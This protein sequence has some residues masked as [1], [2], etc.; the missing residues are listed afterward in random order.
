[1]QGRERTPFLTAG[2]RWL[3]MV[4]YEV[5]PADLRAYVPRGTELDLFDGRCLVS[6]VGFLFDRARLF[7]RIPIPGHACFEEVNLRFYVTRRSGEQTRRGVVFI[8]ELAPS[9]SVRWVARAVFHENYHYVPMRHRFRW[10]DPAAP[11]AG[12][13]FRYLWRSGG[14]WS[15][16]CAETRGRLAPPAAGSLAEFIIEHYWGYSMRRDGATLAYAVDHPRW[17]VWQVESCSLQANLPALYGPRLA[18]PLSSAPHSALVADGS[19][20]VLYHG[21]PV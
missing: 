15:E 13:R 21:V 20:V 7:G 3:V 8:K 1:M 9:R 17:K 18:R 12:G 10:N 16:L 2:W 6:V 4:N 19:P 5:D 14:R 11:Q